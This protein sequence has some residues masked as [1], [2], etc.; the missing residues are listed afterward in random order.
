MESNRALRAWMLAVVLLALAVTAGTVSALSERD[1]PARM[2]PATLRPSSAQ[3]QAQGLG[4][5]GTFTLALAADAWTLDPAAA[6]DGVSWLVKGQ[7]Y[8]TLVNTRRNTP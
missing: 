1:H 8:D 5:G 6:T 7:I 2:S 3:D 4:A